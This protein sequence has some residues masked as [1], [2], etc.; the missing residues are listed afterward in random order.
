MNLNMQI[1]IAARNDFAARFALAQVGGKYKD[2]DYPRFVFENQAQRN[3]YERI[4]RRLEEEDAKVFGSGSKRS[5]ATTI[6]NTRPIGGQRI[7][8]NRGISY[9]RISG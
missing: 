3:E 6:R 4:L 5:E 9:P 7:Y 2:G 1:R 8:S